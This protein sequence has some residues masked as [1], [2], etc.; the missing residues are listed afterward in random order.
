MPSAVGLTISLTHLYLYLS[1]V[2]KMRG[3]KT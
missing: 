2:P 3:R 1:E